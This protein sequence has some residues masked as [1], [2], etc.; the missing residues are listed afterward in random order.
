M[1][2]FDS[3]QY[4]KYGNKKQKEV[5]RILSEHGIMIKLSEY[6]PILTG[7]IPINIDIKDSDLDIT[8]HYKNKNQ[9]I[10]EVT[11]VFN[12]Y[13]D[14]I[15][16]TTIKKG[17]ETVIS[18]FQI[19]KYEIEIFG[20]NRPTKEQESYRH[21]IIEDKILKLKGPDFRK[22][23]IELKKQGIK[24]EPA[25]G[26]LLKLGDNPYHELLNHKI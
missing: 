1:N 21:M 6:S 16:K 3:I 13:H 15:L 10:N 12:V 14:F 25:F 19:G 8:C 2:K 20:Q 24:T 11:E 17:F 9:F 22:K 18:K 26:I 7:T 4:L 5:Y 23:I